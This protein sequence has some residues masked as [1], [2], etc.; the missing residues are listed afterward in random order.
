MN[1]IAAH[2]FAPGMELVAIFNRNIANNAYVE[3]G[4]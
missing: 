2:Q 4:I 1:E 3:A